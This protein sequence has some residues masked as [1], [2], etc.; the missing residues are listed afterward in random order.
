M[1]NLINFEESEREWRKN[2]KYIGKGQFVYL[3]AYIHKNTNK[4]CRRTILA[5]R[6]SYYYMG[7][8]GIDINSKLCYHP[9]KN[10][11][12]KRHLNRIPLNTL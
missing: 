12:C 5:Q 1:N 4:Q 6:R 9:N 10:I 2:K 7:F 8:G 11:F 3:C